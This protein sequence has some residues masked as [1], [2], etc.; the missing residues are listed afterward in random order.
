QQPWLQIR[1]RLRRGQGV[2]VPKSTAHRLLERVRL[3]PTTVAELRRQAIEIGLSPFAVE[4]LALLGRLTFPINA[5]WRE[6]TPLGGIDHEQNRIAT[7]NW[8]SVH[9]LRL[10]L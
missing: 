5:P 10:P 7:A 3:A 8:G 2:K 4:K 6:T 1:R 9:D